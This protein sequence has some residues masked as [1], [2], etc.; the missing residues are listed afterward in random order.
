MIDFDAFNS[1]LLGTDTFAQSA[2]FTPGGGAAT[3]VTVVLELIPEEINL[4]GEMVPQAVAGKAGCK[5]SDVTGAKLNDI[6]E[7]AGVS[8]RILKVEVDETGWATLYLGK[9]Y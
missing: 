1:E 3:P 7:V 4:G 6:L 9:R 8:Y 5:A 2:T